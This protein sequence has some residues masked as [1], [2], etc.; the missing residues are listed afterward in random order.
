M[1]EDSY[2][3]IMNSGEMDKIVLEQGWLENEENWSQVLKFC[4]DA[5][6]KDMLNEEFARYFYNIVN[7]TTLFSI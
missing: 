7:F 4:E 5:E 3:T 2:T 6:L 1:A